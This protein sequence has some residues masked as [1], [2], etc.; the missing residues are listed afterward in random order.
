[1][2]GYSEYQIAESLH[3]FIPISLPLWGGRN[4]VDKDGRL[5]LHQEK[6]ETRYG[7]ADTFAYI[8]ASLPCKS[9]RKWSNMG[10]N[11]KLWKMKEIEILRY[12]LQNWSEIDFVKSIY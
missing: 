4:P 12:F 5:S 11:L 2:Y 9:L 1:M 7:V 6:G 3:I 10:K 8:F